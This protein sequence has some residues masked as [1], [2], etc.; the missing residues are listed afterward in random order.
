[1]YAGRGAAGNFTI[2]PELSGPALNSL[3]IIEQPHHGSNYT[4]RSNNT[5]QKGF[6]QLIVLRRVHIFF[7][8]SERRARFSPARFS[9]VART[10]LS[11]EIF[12]AKDLS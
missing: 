1:V 11:M 12:H 10:Q 2:F 6:Q 3:K 5:T 9:P 4:K 7:A 8:Q